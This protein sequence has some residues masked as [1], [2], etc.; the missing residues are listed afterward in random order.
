MCG[1]QRRKSLAQIL[2]REMAVL[3]LG[4]DK[5]LTYKRKYSSQCQISFR[6]FSDQIGLL[7]HG[8]ELSEIKDDIV[9]LK[10][11]DRCKTD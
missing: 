11:I 9:A 8:E 7:D 4:A 5:M 6:L 2:I 1:N 3:L 10:K